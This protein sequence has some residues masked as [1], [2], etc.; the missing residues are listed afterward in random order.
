MTLY[1]VQRHQGQRF[2]WYQRYLP[3][4]HRHSPD[5]DRLRLPDSELV[6]RGPAALA[7]LIQELAS[8]PSPPED[9]SNGPMPAEGFDHPWQVLPAHVWEAIHSRY[10]HFGCLQDEVNWRCQYYL[11][12]V[13]PAEIPPGTLDGERLWDSSNALFI[14][15]PCLDW[16]ELNSA[17]ETAGNLTA[18]L[19]AWAREFERTLQE[20]DA[21]ART[22]QRQ[23]VQLRLRLEA[24]WKRAGR[25]LEDLLGS[26]GAS[27]RS[28]ARSR[29]KTEVIDRALSV[30]RD[31][32]LYENAPSEVRDL[33]R[34]TLR[35]IVEDV[36]NHELFN[37][38]WSAVG[39]VAQ[40]SADLLA[41][42][43][44]LNPSANL[45]SQLSDLVLDRIEAAVRS[46]FGG[47]NPRIE[48][49]IPVKLDVGPIHFNEKFE[50]GRVSI[51]LGS[52]TDAV[53]SALRSLAFFEDAMRELADEIGNAADAAADKAR[54][55][56]E[57]SDLLER[58]D[59][60][61]NPGKLRERLASLV[62]RATGDGLFVRTV[63]RRSLFH[64]RFFLKLLH[65]PPRGYILV[66]WDKRDDDLL[67]FNELAAGS[68]AAIPVTLQRQ[69]GRS[70]H[71][72]V[73][74]WRR[75]NSPPAVFDALVRVARD[76]AG[77]PTLVVI[78]FR[79]P[80]PGPP[81]DENVWRV[82]MAGLPSDG[83][84]FGPADVFFDVLIHE[85]FRLDRQSGLHT[86]SWNLATETA[87]TRERVARYCS[88]EGRRR[89]GTSLWF[90]NIVGH[91]SAPDVL[92][93]A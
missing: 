35:S 76:S 69:D 74:G 4:D 1:V 75:V 79:T 47:N 46:H 77:R 27:G 14:R 71:A 45:T 86:Y 48:L 30:L 17:I 29:V 60:L 37:A 13:D 25:R 53:R 51:P 70:V 20:L 58:I 55:E 54:A 41:D 19:V 65:R 28:S 90:E 33:A 66:H 21:A 9:V 36:L 34:D 12:D 18:P 5:G 43:R 16:H 78:R 22:I 85:T 10:S 15:Q 93:F 24:A 8:P 61:V 82:R 92:T 6:Q 23:V 72:V 3:A 67:P 38:L 39:G 84:T 42:L 81:L 89:H 32:P 7:R 88:D 68:R 52:L 87:G 31:V 57:R 2:V 62:A 56:L 83:A 91:V 80:V 26:V 44:R 59:A 11:V 50:L 40:E 64:D 73:R 63:H 49:S